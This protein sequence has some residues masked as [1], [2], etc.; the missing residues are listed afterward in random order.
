MIK[1][2]K[3]WWKYLTAK[4]TG[5]FNES[6]DPKVQLEEVIRAIDLANNISPYTRC[7]ECN[8]KLESAR[9]SDVAH[10]IPLQVFLVYRSFKRCKNCR[11]V[12]WRGSHLKRLDKIVEQ[13]CNITAGR[14]S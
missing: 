9:R 8:G 7:M 14:E 5:K 12:Y 13:A 11:R 1:L 4:L 6:A 10:S 2:V 3:R